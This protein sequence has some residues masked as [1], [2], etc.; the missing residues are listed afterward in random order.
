MFSRFHFIETRFPIIVLEALT[1]EKDE[2]IFIRTSPLFLN[3]ECLVTFTPYC[4]LF[5]DVL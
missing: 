5:Y 4:T 2:E 1:K 3:I